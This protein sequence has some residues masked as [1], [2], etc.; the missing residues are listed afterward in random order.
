MFT[1][2]T[3][4]SQEWVRIHTNVRRRSFLK[5]IG[6]GGAATVVAGCL[7]GNGG[8][9]DPIVIGS[10]QPLSGSFASFGQAHDA[11]MQ[12]AAQ[13]IN[14]DGGLLDQELVIETGDTGSDPREG[15]SIFR[16]MVEHNGAVAVA[17]PVSSDLGIRVA[18]TAEQME[19]PLFLHMAG[20]GDAL[21]RDS[22]HTYRVGLIPAPTS[23]RAEADLVAA[24]GFDSVGI[25]VADYAWGR[26]FE[27]AVE[28]EYPDDVDVHLEVAPL[29]EDEY[30]SYLRQ[31]P[32]D[33]DMISTTGN[34]PGQNAIY[35][36]QYE[37]DFGPEIT[38]DAS[39]PPRTTYSG[40]G[41]LV[42]RS[43]AHYHLIDVHS[44]GYHEVASRFAESED[45][46]M[47]PNEGYGYVTVQLIAEAIRE[48]DS[49]D[50]ATVSETVRNMEFDTPLY[51]NP[52]SYTEWGELADP[53]A[54]YSSFE[55]E[56]P[57][58]FPDGEWRLEDLHRTDPL[59]PY[60]PGE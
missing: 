45:E 16:E 36:Q 28:A 47:T 8:D 49:T 5:T 26:A 34:A 58:Y 10:L 46:Y 11:G 35:Q 13:E 50:P 33:V 54:I 42:E 9:D 23:V 2:M 24:Q 37:F 19:V 41:D 48:S 14:E 40:V 21:S 59:E 6:A 30:S 44:E 7:G 27:E 39:I 60:D 12:F 18:Q 51:P 25:I 53:I 52:I 1:Q 22:R 3:Q 15:D 55:L 57:E 4:D 17:G 20:T 29:G 43:L 32:E 31:I 56:A 38:A